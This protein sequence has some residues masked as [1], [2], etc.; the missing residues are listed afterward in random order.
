M[1][2]LFWTVAI[3]C[4]ALMVGQSADAQDELERELQAQALEKKVQRLLERAEELH[5]ADQR[6]EAEEL[7]HKA[8]DLRAK[9]EDARDRQEREQDKGR[10]EL[11]EVLHGLEYGMVALKKLGRHEELRM[12]ER[13]AYDVREEIAGRRKE[14]RGRSEKEIGLHQIEVMR[15]AM[16]AL[17][18]AERKDAAEIVEQAIHARELAMEGRRDEKAMEIRK[19]A[20]DLGIQVEILMHAADLW[21][22]FGHERK[23]ATIRELAG[24]FREKLER[25]KEGG[26]RR[27]EKC[28]HAM[29]Q[30]EI[31]KSALHALKEGGKEDA[32]DILKRVIQARIV[33]LEGMRGKEAEI[34]RE[35]NP[36][37]EQQVE[38]LGLASRL[39]R[40]WG[41]EEKARAIGG[42]AERM[43]AQRRQRAAN[44]QNVDM[45]RFRE[46][47]EK[48]EHMA[49]QIEELKRALRDR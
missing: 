4:F 26:A 5:H 44:Q 17:L 11:E 47:E 3:F 7:R 1:R 23:A 34:V 12:L 30:I 18:E 49:R 20:P 38:I 35:R 42:L 28:E 40:E 25:Q 21:D 32:A 39:C 43:W 31:M 19:N 27:D 24:Q 9:I 15:L 14:E 8:E 6:E 45:R 46:L 41:N 33:N 37:L 48:M 22:E 36:P 10:S 13:V 29:H 2:G 16:K